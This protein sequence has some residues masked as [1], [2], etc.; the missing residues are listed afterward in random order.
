[1]DTESAQQAAVLRHSQ[2]QEQASAILAVRIDERNVRE[3][4]LQWPDPLRLSGA[5][6]VAD[7]EEQSQVF[8]VQSSYSQSLEVISPI[9]PVTATKILAA[10]KLHRNRSRRHSS[11]LAS[12][13]QKLCFSD[14]TATWSQQPVE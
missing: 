5:A 3:R 1:M 13:G 7:L 10:S 11:S 2:L 8:Q 6:T 9:I 14:S 4:D 12:S